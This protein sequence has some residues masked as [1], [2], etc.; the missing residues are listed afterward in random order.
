MTPI[1]VLQLFICKM[2]II[3]STSQS[4]DYE[5][6]YSMENTLHKVT[7]G[8]NSLIKGRLFP[9]FLAKRRFPRVEPP[10]F[11][12]LPSQDASHHKDSGLL[13]LICLIYRHMG[14]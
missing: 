11:C 1:S 13:R 6:R 7:A 12:N 5:I 8:S 2:E 9:V 4:C 10:A 3:I 14:S